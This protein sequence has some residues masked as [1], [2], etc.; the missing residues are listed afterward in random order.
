VESKSICEQAIGKRLDGWGIHSLLFQ[1]AYADRDHEAMQRQLEWATGTSDESA[2][3]S[4]SA[5]AE[6]TS[7]RIKRALDLFRRSRDAA[8]ARDL[9][10]G[11]AEAEALSALVEAVVGH[12]AEAREHA[13]ASIQLSQTFG[14][15]VDALLALALSGNSDRA[16]AL[17]TEL[18]RRWPLDTVLT[19]AQVPLVRAA[20]AVDRKHPDEAIDLLRTAAPFE[21]RDFE[22]VFTRG[23]AYLQA[24][25]GNEAASEFQKI[26]DHQ[27]VDPI[28]LFIPLAQLE[29]GRARAVAG[30]PVGA[31]RAYDAFFA[32]WKDA[33]ADLPVLQE[34]HR[35]AA[36]LR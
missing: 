34:G 30:D 11:E 3:L 6:A 16:A 20:I 35:E 19:E 18:S 28:S 10:E 4:T 23:V 33:D 25:R 13:D 5:A 8:R 26:L 1:I 32:G 27:G 21:L 2:M 9:K 12:R 14:P 15:M 29:L 22:V 7:G 36:A 31:R 17:A 24:R